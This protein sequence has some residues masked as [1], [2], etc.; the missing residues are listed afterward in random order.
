MNF[1]DPFNPANPNSILWDDDDEVESAVIQPSPEHV[2][3]IESGYTVPVLCCVC[4]LLLILSIA[5]FGSK[6]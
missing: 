6:D 3:T 1:D 4:F 2:N 5:A